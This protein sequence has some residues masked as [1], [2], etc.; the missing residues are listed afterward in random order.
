M[1]TITLT[2]TTGELVSIGLA[3]LFMVA[4]TILGMRALSHEATRHRALEACEAQHQ[5]MCVL[6]AEPIEREGADYG[7]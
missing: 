7:Q 5:A 2:G 1:K 6:V 4:C 3:L